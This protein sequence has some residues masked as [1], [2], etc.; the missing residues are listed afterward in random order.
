MVTQRGIEFNPAQVK[1]VLETPTPS[2]KKELQRVIGRLAALGRFITRFIDN[3][4]HFFHTL[5]G[6]SM[7]SWTNECKETFEV[8]KH[9]LTEPPILS[10]PNSR[11]ELYMYLALFDCAISV[12]L[13]WHI[14]DREQRPIYYVSKAMVD[15]ETQYSRV[16]Q[17]ALAL[18][19]VARKLGP[20]F[21]Q[22]PPHFQVCNIRCIT[23][24]QL[25]RCFTNFLLRYF[26]LYMMSQDDN[27]PP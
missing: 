18:K 14:Q 5:K 16:Q 11:K 15:A 9:Y 6:I 22:T 13:F 23:L 4:W 3:L 20:Y 25:I 10:I 19:S 7:F 1:V 26:I 21:S 17:T 8:V 27:F 24:P 12:A 2:S